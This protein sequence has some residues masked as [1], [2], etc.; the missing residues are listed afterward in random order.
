MYKGVFNPRRD[1]RNLRREFNRFVDGFFGNDAV[2]EGDFWRPAI[3]MV[4]TGEA[5]IIAAEL[6]GMK[7]EDIKINIQENSL[8]L[9]G[10]KK[11]FRDEKNHLRSECCY[12]PFKRSVIIPGETNRDKVTA[13]YESGILQITLPK[14]EESQAKGIKI[15]VN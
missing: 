5:Y 3:D 13:K 9:S 1:L 12:G 7:K 14:K 8:T 6:P 11:P 4:E 15:E 10:E 2:W